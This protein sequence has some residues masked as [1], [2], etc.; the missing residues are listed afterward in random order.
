M[1]CMN[2]TANIPPQWVACLQENKCP[3][4]GKDIMG[5]K[6]KDL[7]DELRE[8]MVRMPND[9][10]GLAGWLLSNYKLHKIGDAEPTEFHQMRHAQPQNPNEG[11]PNNLKIANN[12]V[13]KFLQ[14][15]GYSKQIDNR[16]RL[17][18]IV[19][20]IDHGPQP[21]S[22]MPVSGMYNVDY[23]PVI[24]LD[25]APMED[26]DYD[27]DMPPQHPGMAAQALANSVVMGGSGAPINPDEIR[28]MAA[29]V[30]G[31]GGGG[32]GAPQVDDNIHPALQRDR[33]I[34]LQKQRDIASGGGQGS[35]RRSG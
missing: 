1:D 22:Q 12:P 6:S 19:N 21:T 24:D 18:D 4:C 26:Y 2:C 33:M 25:A 13:H 7:L 15:T 27:Y 16:K 20:E 17:K 9:P 14:R 3:S 10:E 34:R 35:F 30:S 31:A 29:A 28:A 8:A 23:D 5:E 11:V 32:G